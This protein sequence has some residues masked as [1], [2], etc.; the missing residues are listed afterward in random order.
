MEVVD[1]I[2]SEY[3][4]DALYICER[5]YTTPEQKKKKAETVKKTILLEAHDNTIVKS[6]NVADHVVKNA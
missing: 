1:N 5:C 3:I 2:L 6:E 4:R